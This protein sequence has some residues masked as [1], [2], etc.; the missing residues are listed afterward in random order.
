[1]FQFTTPNK[2]L[3]G[4]D[5]VATASGIFTSL[6]HHALIVTG[7]NVGKS[8]MV[9]TLERTL[10]RDGVKYTVL[11]EITGE[12]TT[13][14]VAHGVKAY[15]EHECDFIIGLGGGSPL[16]ASKAIAA[17]TVL[18]GKISD[19]RG[20]NITTEL[21]P[22]VCIPTTAGTGSEVTKYTI[23][24]D[25]ESGVKM[26]LTGDSLLPRV[27]MVDYTFSNSCPPSVT[28]ATAIDALTHAIEAFVSV[29]AQPLS[30]A[31]ALSAIKRIMRY[32]PK[33]YRD[34]TD[35]EAR[36]ELAIAATQA[37]LCINNSSVTIVHGMSRP[38][39]ATFH[40]PHGV[41]NAML[42]GTCL[43]DLEQAARHNL[44][45]IAT[46]MRIHAVDEIDA[47][48]K[49]VAEV[50][51]LL[52]KCEIPSLMEFGIDEREFEAAIVKMSHDAIDSGSPSHAPKEYTAE[53]I[54]SLY[55][56]AYHRKTKEQEGGGFFSS[57]RK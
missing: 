12:P 28:A 52:N 50:E 37:G 21:P 14:M 46:Y 55:R 4:N 29:Q 2:I 30:D 15:R 24:T 13:A 43:I 48:E 31:L 6:G 3:M 54:Q 8:T 38:L 35:M 17:M 9:A 33:A 7:P 36:R 10:D 19:Y 34:G 26:L 23:I 1:M 57:L 47:S 44:A 16:D 18:P 25:E 56:K 20:R 32:L 39:G 27:A 41:S 49:F 11:D 5:I 40:V 22:L 51:K 42:L 53:Q 45:R